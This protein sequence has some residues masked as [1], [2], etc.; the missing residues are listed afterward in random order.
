MK[1]KDFILF[2]KQFESVKPALSL[3]I[4]SEAKHLAKKLLP[5]HF[6]SFES[7]N[8]SPHRFMEEVE[9]TSLFEPKRFI[10]VEIGSL[11]AQCT[12]TILHYLKSPNPKTTLILSSE[13]LSSSSKIFKEI[14]KR[15]QILNLSEE[16]P[17]DKEK[18][19]ITRTIGFAKQGGVVLET[20]EAKKL[21]NH[22]NKDPIALESELRKIICFIG[23]R[24]KITAEDLN[25]IFFEK[26]TQTLWQLGDSLFTQP[27]PIVFEQLKS[28][29][30][31]G[32]SIFPL[33]AHFKNQLRQAICALNLYQAQ[34]MDPVLKLFPY[35][36]EQKMQVYKNHGLEKLKQGFLEVCYCE[37]KAKN[38]VAD[39]SLL[40]EL[41]IEKLCS[42]Y[43]PTS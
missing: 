18:D 26:Q 22:L 3:I 4:S 2:K 31:E 33:L 6:I 24:K 35:F 28:L 25:L 37:V 20:A 43:C 41:L 29:L 10:H 40:L 27:F 17:W 7:D 13:T 15:G 8:F 34:G 21:V 1:F 12:E 39:G 23:Q 36:K 16:K 42:I 14:E 32:I 19:L 9:S 11:N 5:P 30:E 38:S